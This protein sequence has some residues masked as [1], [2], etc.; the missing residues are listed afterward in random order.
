MDHACGIDLFGKAYCWGAEMW[1]EIGDDAPPP[2]QVFYL[3]GAVTP[4]APVLGGLT[5]K[6]VD[7]G[8][9]H[10]C[11][12]TIAGKVYC[13]GY[14]GYGQ[15]GTNNAQD[16]RTSPLYPN[17][18]SPVP[19]PVA[20]NLTFTYVTTGLSHT[21]ALTTTGDIWCWGVAGNVGAGNPVPNASPCPSFS[22]N[23]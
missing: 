5:F 13:W 7:A 11:G 15:L 12:V 18:C 6:Q 2:D 22:Q 14:N 1:G 4:P 3:Y 19:V 23:K 20:S 8:R 9:V 16:C 21:C 10:S 17:P